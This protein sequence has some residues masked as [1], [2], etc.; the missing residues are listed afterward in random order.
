MIELAASFLRGSYTPLVTPFSNMTVDHDVYKSLVEHQIKGG[1][2]GIVVTGTSGE[3]GVLTPAER[4]ELVRTAVTTADGRIP[5]VAATGAESL[6]ETLRITDGAAKAGADALLVVTPYYIKPP[7]RGLIDYFTEVAAATDLPLL[8]Y[9]IPGRAGVTLAIES[10]QAIMSSAPTVVGMKHASPDLGYATTLLRTVDS[11]FR[12]FVGLEQ[13]SLPLLV[14]GASGLMNAVGNIA[15]RAVADL[16]EAITHGDLSEARRLNSTLEE[17]NE[18]VFWDTNPI[19]IKYLMKRLGLIA[20]NEHR[21][22]MSPATFELQRQLD[23]LLLRSP[24]LTSSMTAPN[25][26]I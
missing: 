21:L 25:E 6:A 5:V 9:H 3:P 11:E 18:A 16:C 13:L 20:E 2:H 15:P 12:L 24:I 22:P 10:V 8:I 4:I 7:Q 1:S 19:P 26:T 17:L 23:E 14:L